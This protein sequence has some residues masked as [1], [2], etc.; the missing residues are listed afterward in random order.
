MRISLESII[1]NA[2]EIFEYS[3]LLNRLLREREKSGDFNSISNMARVCSRYLR[4]TWRN[5]SYD[6]SESRSIGFRSLE[7]VVLEKLL[8]RYLRTLY[9]IELRITMLRHGVP[10]KFLVNIPA[11]WI[12]FFFFFLRLHRDTIFTKKRLE[13]PSFYFYYRVE[14]K[15]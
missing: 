10:L 6:Q 3:I 5:C 11:L 14:K 4:R 9:T 15:T 2:H 12:S 13:S 8:H 1:R 7:A